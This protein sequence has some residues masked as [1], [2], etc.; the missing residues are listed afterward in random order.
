MQEQAF[1]RGGRK[2]RARGLRAGRE[3]ER[4]RE[5]ERGIVALRCIAVLR[6]VSSLL[7]DVAKLAGDDGGGSCHGW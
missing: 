4:E 1:G 3:R 2:G 7:A 5:R 6:K